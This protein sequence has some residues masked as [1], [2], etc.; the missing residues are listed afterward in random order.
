VLQH[1]CPGFPFFP[2]SERGPAFCWHCQPSPLAAS[3]QSAASAAANN[4]GSADGRFPRSAGMPPALHGLSSQSHSRADKPSGAGACGHSR[5]GETRPHA[6]PPGAHWPRNDGDPPLLLHR[7]QRL[8]PALV[9]PKR[10]CAAPSVKPKRRPRRTEFVEKPIVDSAHHLPVAG[11]VS[12]ESN[13]QRRARGGG[14]WWT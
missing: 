10:R 6:A 13:R 9:K 1:N 8:H 2:T 14:G 11:Q 5:Q 4:A 7:R 12:G 3:T